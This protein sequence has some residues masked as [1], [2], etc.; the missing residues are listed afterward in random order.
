[1]AA[2]TGSAIAEHGNLF[3][4]EVIVELKLAFGIDVTS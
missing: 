4:D 1:M 3:L 2:K